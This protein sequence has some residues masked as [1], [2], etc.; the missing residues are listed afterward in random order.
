MSALAF[1]SK[2]DTFPFFLV[3]SGSFLPALFWLWFWLR[4]DKVHPEPPLMLVLAFLGGMASV[5]TALVLQN[6]LYYYKIDSNS[7]SI[8]FYVATEELSKFFFAYIIALRSRSDDEPVDPL[9]YMIA[10][11]LG[12]SALEN[13][14]FTA[15]S[16]LQTGGLASIYTASLRYF[17]ATVLHVLASG[18]IGVAL[19][20]SFYK[21]HEKKFIFTTIGIVVAIFLHTAFNLLI[22]R[23]GGSNLVL[24]FVPFWIAV[25]LLILCFER[26]KKIFPLPPRFARQ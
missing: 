7:L 3:L 24:V 15:G 25:L 5:F 1:I 4:E 9:I 8:V 13:T 11:A 6:L 17:G 2:L 18:S 19:G 14:L 20:F 22:I 12:F 23:Y 16:L 26:I 10:T 21:N